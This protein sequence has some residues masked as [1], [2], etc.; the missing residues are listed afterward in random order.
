M[1][2]FVQDNKRFFAVPLPGKGAPVGNPGG[3]A[4]IGPLGVDTELVQGWKQDA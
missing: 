1:A 3:G 2:E 4:G